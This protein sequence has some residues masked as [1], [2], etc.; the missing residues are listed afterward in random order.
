MKDA[1]YKYK[2]DITDAANEFERRFDEE[3]SSSY[4]D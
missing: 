3:M 1:K 2:L 4:F